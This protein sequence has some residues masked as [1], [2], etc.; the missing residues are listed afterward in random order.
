VVEDLRVVV[1]TGSQRGKLFVYWRASDKN[2]EVRPITLSY[3]ENPKEGLWT[4]INSQPLSNTS[5][6]VWNMPADVPSQFY[7]RVEAADRAGNVGQ[8]VTQEAVRVDLSIP[9]A[10]IIQVDSN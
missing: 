9:R 2:L 6:Y 7:V 5:S 4:K 10:K 3:S 8:A 1:G